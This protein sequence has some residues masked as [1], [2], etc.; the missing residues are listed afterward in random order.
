MDGR[1]LAT[2]DKFREQQF[3]RSVFC[4]TVWF[5]GAMPWSRGNKTST[6]MR[7][8]AVISAPRV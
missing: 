8:L 7:D 3:Q 6:R 1:R 2:I 4:D 5:A